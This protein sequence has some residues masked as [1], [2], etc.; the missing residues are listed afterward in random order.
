MQS[1]SR[2]EQWLWLV[3]DQHLGKET[4][5]T[6]SA[7]WLLWLA[8]RPAAWLSVGLSDSCHT[9]IGLPAPCVSAL[10]VDQNKLPRDDLSPSLSPALQPFPPYLSLHVSPCLP[11]HVIC[12]MSVFLS[13]S[14]FPSICLS[15]LHAL[16]ST[17]FKTH[18]QRHGEITF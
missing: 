3:I 8:G 1:W 7:V 4:A 2:E 11:L 9:V 16:P 14:L 18:K 10:R 6:R 17:Y 12:C 13:P 15:R 5:C